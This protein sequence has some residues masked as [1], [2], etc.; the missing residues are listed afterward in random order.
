MAEQIIEDLRTRIL[1]GHLPRGARLPSERELAT[2]FGVSGATVREAIRAL[3]AAHMIEVR[4]GSGAYVTADAEQL[5]AQSLNTMIRIERI[6]AHDIM[7][8]LAVLN[9]HAAEL[10][11]QRA[12][13]D[14]VAEL[15]ASLDAIDAARHANEVQEA[16]SRFLNALAGAAHQA[17][18]A[19]LCKF[20][21]ALQFARA[22]QI[23]AGKASAWRTTA[24]SLNKERRA[25]VAAIAK[26][27]VALARARA[28]AYH[29]RA[30]QVIDALS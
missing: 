4:H 11:A 30:V 12:T 25:L 15:R 13:P 17:L 10:A 24:S 7:G 23:A 21:T 29:E 8:V 20:L 27:N 26:G 28:L 2:A 1:D 9:V 18:L 3:A 6:D 22:R 19:S 14:D 5:I 16:L